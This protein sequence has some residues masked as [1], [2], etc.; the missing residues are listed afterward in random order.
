[1]IGPLD[2]EIE[3]ANEFRLTWLRFLFENPTQSL[4]LNINININI[5]MNMHLLVT[6]EYTYMFYWVIEWSSSCLHQFVVVWALGRSRQCMASRPHS[7]GLIAGWKLK[8]LQSCCRKFT[9]IWEQICNI[10]K[11]KKS[12]QL[13]CSLKLKQVVAAIFPSL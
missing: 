13:E 3:R 6:C 12:G 10:K 11:Q 2:W 8:M 4:E 1:M 9:M 7:A 5:N